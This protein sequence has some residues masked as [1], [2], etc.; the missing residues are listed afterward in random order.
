MVTAA[1]PGAK[2]GV[3]AAHKEPPPVDFVVVVTFN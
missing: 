2:P 1:K 3:I